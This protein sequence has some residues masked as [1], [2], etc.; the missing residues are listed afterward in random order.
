MYDQC[1]FIDFCILNNPRHV[2]KT[3]IIELP[4]N[5]IHQTGLSEA[6]LRLKIAIELFKEERL[7]LGQASQLAGIHR[8]AFQQELGKRKVPVHYDEEMLEND[9][10]TLNAI[11]GDR[12]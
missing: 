10:K 5:L 6:E 12:R 9:L 4:D 1:G 3:M 2:N 8:L 7:S 11:F